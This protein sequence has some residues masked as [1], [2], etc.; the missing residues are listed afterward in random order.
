MAGCC[1]A[2]RSIGPNASRPVVSCSDAGVTAADC[3]MLSIGTQRG[4]F[5]T[6]ITARPNQAHR[7]CGPLEE[8]SS[9]A[10]AG[11][12]R[13]SRPAAINGR[14]AGSSAVTEG[15]AAGVASTTTQGRA[16]AGK[17]TLERYRTWSISRDR[18]LLSLGTQRGAF[19]T[20]ITTRPNQAHRLCGPLEQASS[21]SSAGLNRGSRPAAING[22]TA[23]PSAVTEGEAAG[24][25][26]TTT[27]LSV[28][29]APSTT[30]VAD[31]NEGST[32]VIAA[33][34]RAV[35]AA[36]KS[37]KTGAGVTRRRGSGPLQG[38]IRGI[39]ESRRPT[40]D[41][42]AALITDLLTFSLG[43]GDADLARSDNLHDEK[44]TSGDADLDHSLDSDVGNPIFVQK[45][46]LTSSR[47][48][49]GNRPTCCTAGSN[50]STDHAASSAVS[51]VFSS[52]SSS[53]ARQQNLDPTVGRAGEGGADAPAARA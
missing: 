51:R 3:C 31:P 38:F 1:I 52:E 9:A 4:A 50:P 53:S 14:T 6:A 42:D 5:C 19:C 32:G 21:A 11:L 26:S 35:A 41:E 23:G 46:S 22:R 13:G 33:G 27:R 25:A 2:G 37:P 29:D 40:G 12:N 39:R 44:R 24:V 20:A 49:S 30:E 47:D 28:G 10:S 17:M 18:M 15:E 45:S 7:L 16:A 8:A 43:G 36:R 48:N 34:R